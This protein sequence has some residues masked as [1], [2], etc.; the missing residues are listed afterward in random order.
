MKPPPLKDDCFALPPGVT[1]TPVDQALELLRSRLK[2]VVAR[3]EIRVN[4]AVGRIAAE[5]VRAKRDNPPTANSA[6]DGYGFRFHAPSGDTYSLDLLAGR[7]A[8][9]APFHGSVVAGQAVR[10]LT[11]A[12]LP[13]G[14]D[15][16]VMQEDVSVSGGKIAFRAGIAKG[17]NARVGGEDVRQGTEIVAAGKRLT[18]QDIALL[19]ATGV[20]SISVFEPLRVGVLSTGD[21]IAEPGTID[22]PFTTYDANRPMLA[23]LLSQWQ[24][25]AVDLGH[26]CDDRGALRDRLNGASRSVDA[27]LTSGGASAGDEDHLSAILRE[28]G[29]MTTWRIAIKPGRPLALGQWNAVPVFG[30][31]GN[32]VAAFVCS[33]IFARPAL[34]CLAGENWFAPRGFPLPAAFSKNKKAGRREYL[35]AR[36]NEQ[37]EAEV[38]PSEGSGRIAGLSWSEGLVELG[39]EAALIKP[40]TPVRFIPYASFGI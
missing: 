18:A 2:P 25:E 11:G 10:I 19:A 16:V 26:V 22:S 1:W 8:A 3:T 31:P 9:G 34:G 29:A 36:V 23:A 37:G 12:A 20:D 15:T 17:A 6:V 5:A 33:L 27:I 39:D 24:F 14:V 35:R 30:L 40:G 38:Y 13:D 32:P 21:E 7:A 4:G 28:E